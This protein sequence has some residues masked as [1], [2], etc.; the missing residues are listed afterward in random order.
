MKC[1]SISLL[2]IFFAST[3][4]LNAQKVC[5]WDQLYEINKN[6]ELFANY[7][8]NLHKSRKL[9]SNLKTNGIYT[10]PT[11]FHVIYKN[12]LENVSNA[13]IQSQLDVLNEDFRKL[14]TDTINVEGSFSIA[15]V[16]IEFC[17]AQRDPDGNKASGIT[18][19]ETS[20]D[21]VCIFT[22]TQFAQIAPA[23]DSEKYLNIWV[24]D[25]N[26]TVAGYAF[27]P[28][29]VSKDRD[30]VVID[31]SNFGTSG[32]AVFP[33]DGGRTVTHEIGHWLDLIHP[34]GLIDDNSNCAR[35]DQVSDTPLQ[36]AP[37]FGCESNRT[38]CGSLDML[39]NFMGFQDDRCMGNFTDGQKTRMRNALTMERDSLIVSKGCL[40]VGLEE[41][42][43]LNAIKIY[44]NPV[45]TVLKLELP[46]DQRMNELNVQ[47]K[48]VIGRSISSNLIV[49]Q[50][51]LTIDT[52]WL[53]SGIYFIQLKL[54]QKERI[55]K[56]LVQH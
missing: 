1:S 28:G 55:K 21:D 53:K 37:V 45:N 26:N 51:G 18:R 30:G 13:Q 22:S 5:G 32:S 42:Q 48:D 44:P 41:V 4:T 50:D 20:I 6:N 2:L 47:L 40:P 16:H 7:L 8:N 3:F 17:L 10:I 29:G 46:V 31:F 19:T 38:S 52:Q 39:S 27:P 24:C 33:Y 14:N 11:V 12:N 54:G 43:L 23:W 15:D 49:N 25:I 36:D 34:W 9:G 35:D 56:I